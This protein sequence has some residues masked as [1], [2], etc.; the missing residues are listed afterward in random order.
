MKTSLMNI[1]RIVYVEPYPGIATTHVIECGDSVPEIELFSGA[2]GPA[3]HRL[4]EPIISYKDELDVII[5]SLI[6]VETEPSLFDY[7]GT[8]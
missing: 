3:Y 4:Y 8:I 6:D 5:K 7:E 2:I 1:S